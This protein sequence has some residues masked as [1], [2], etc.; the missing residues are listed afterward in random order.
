MHFAEGQL[1]AEE[2]FVRG[3]GKDF[4]S[5]VFQAIAE[6]VAW[7]SCGHSAQVFVVFVEENKAAGT[8]AEPAV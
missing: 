7:E 8:A 6:E 4:G 5:L 3:G 1:D 2:R